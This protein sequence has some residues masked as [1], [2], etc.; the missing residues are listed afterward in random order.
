MGRMAELAVNV[1]QVCE[2]CSSKYCKMCKITV[3]QEGQ[4]VVVNGYTK[5][6]EKVIRIPNFA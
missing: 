6:I 1:E 5:E 3:R 4:K 2:L